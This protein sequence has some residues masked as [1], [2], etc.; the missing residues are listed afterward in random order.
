[1][2]KNRKQ[3]KALKRLMAVCLAGAVAGSGIP[4]YVQAE[5]RILQTL[6]QAAIQEQ[7][8]FNYPFQNTELSFEER[9]A[10]LVSRLT[11]EEK[12]SL[13]TAR[14][15]EGIS[16]VPRLGID[17]WSWGGEANHG[18][19]WVKPKISSF[20]TGSAMSCSWDKELI[21]ETADA[22]SDEARG[23]RALI[24][25]TNNPDLAQLGG[26]SL[27]FW[28]PTMNLNRDP[29]WGR[30]DESYGEDPYLT[31]ELAGS[32][33]RGMQGDDEKYLKTV[34]CLKHF[35]ANNCEKNRYNGSS[36]VDERTL[37]E[38]YAKPFQEIIEATGIAQ[39][40]T[41][42]NSVNGVPM[43]V[44]EPLL[45][46]MLRKTWGFDG[47]VVTDCG[48]IK[49]I[50]NDHKWVP[51]G[52]DRSVNGQEA[53]AFAMKA[54]TDLNCGK[55][56]KQYAQKAL[57]EG[58]LKE[59]DLDRSLLRAFTERM[60]TGEFDPDEMVKYTSLTKEEL[61]SP[62]HIA[63]TEKVANDSV[64]MLKNEAA[65]EGEKPMLPLDGKEMDSVALIGDGRITEK[66]MLGGYSIHTPI[67]STAPI[68]GLCEKMQELNPEATVTLHKPKS[69]TVTTPYLFNIDK[70]LLETKTGEIITLEAEEG[71]TYNCVNEGNNIGYVEPS[72]AFL[73]FPG[74]HIDL[75]DIAKIT[76]VASCDSSAMGGVIQCQ[77]GTPNFQPN[78]ISLA[79]TKV[80]STGSWGNW[81]NF[82]MIVDA[83][84]AELP[85]DGDLYFSFVSE[86]SGNLSKE[87]RK[88]IAEAATAI[89]Y[90]GTIEG[91]DA[92]ED[93]DRKT[94]NLPRRQAELIQEVSSL[95]PNTVV[96]IQSVAQVNVEPFAEQVPAILW[97]G[98]NGQEQGKAF[99]NV[100]FGD[101]NPN[102]KLN[103]TWYQ[104][105]NQIQSITEYGIRSD[106]T[107]NGRTYQYFSG[108]IRYPFGYGLSYTDFTYSNITIDRKE[109]TPNDTITV[110]AD[111]TNSGEVKGKEV[112]QLY[113]KSP[114]AAEKERPV[115][116][117]RGFEKVELEPGE[118]CTVT[119]EVPAEELCYWDEEEGKRIYDPGEYEVEVGA[120]S[121]DIRLKENF[122]MSGEL[123]RKLNVITA[124][125][126]RFIFDLDRGITES[127]IEITASMNDETFCDV[128]KADVTCESSND[129]VAV[130]D[131][132]G[133]IRAVGS[134]TAMITVSI[135][136]EDVTKSVDFP[137]VVRQASVLQ[138]IFV[139][140]KGLTGFMPGTYDYTCKVEGEEAPTITVS[141]PEGIS[142]EIQQAETV[143]GTGIVTVFQGAEQIRYTIEFYHL[144]VSTDFTSGVLNQEEWKVKEE[145]KENWSVDK[146]GLKITTQKGDIIQNQG[147]LKN[148]FLQEVFGDWT[149]DTQLEFSAQPDQRYQQG[150]ILVYQDDD[151]YIKLTC[152]GS[153]GKTIV[154]MAGEQGGKSLTDNPSAA[155]EGTTLYYR[156]KKEGNSYTGWFS[157]DGAEYRELGSKTMDLVNPR[158][159][160]MA[161]NSNQGDAPAIDVIY[162]YTDFS[163]NAEEICTCGLYNLEFLGKTLNLPVD[164]SLTAKAQIRG[165]CVMEGHDASQVDYTYTIPE[166]A[167]NTAEATVENGVLKASRPG[168]VEITVTA[169]LNDAQ[170]VSGKALFEIKNDM[171]GGSLDRLISM[172]EALDAEEYTASSWAE[173]EK[174]LKE[175]KAVREDKNA[176]REETDRAISNLLAAFGNLEYGVQKS[177]LKIAVAAAEELLEKSGDYEDT[178]GLSSAV[179]SGKNVLSDKEADQKTVDEAANRVLDELFKLAKKADLQSLESLIRA[180]GELLDG[181]YTSDSL[182][183]L[184]DVIQK[185]E[186]VIANQDREPNDIGRAYGELVDAI[187]KLERKGSKAALKVMVEKAEYILAEASNYTASTIQ[188]LEEV[189]REAK[190]VYENEDAVQSEVNEAVEKLTQKIA[191]A[192]LLGDVD[193]NGKVTTGDAT[194]VLRAA[195]EFNPVSGDAPASADVNRDGKEDTRDAVLI[196]QYTA[197]EITEF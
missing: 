15:A 89:V 188:G 64:V 186:A 41:A 40:M 81:K 26:G 74:K 131:N 90:V 95:N 119:F 183:N 71:E 70:F 7:K 163:G 103:F 9:A 59:E 37:R 182:Q 38:Y 185:A 92:R 104:K 164:T 133:N 161:T 5:E 124:E 191:Q 115:K 58:L 120:S 11:L 50:V 53:V 30:A 67:H 132:Q 45:D 96:Y 22:I 126:E 153:D 51:E 189:L 105:E 145:D 167:L 181:N 155:F 147:G 174:A 8:T 18:L 166:G 101:V 112:A 84:E 184:K 169:S 31:T 143:P 61:G 29:R 110:T 121:Q 48:A 138:N 168:K 19:S 146:E 10:D 20:P 118:T 79:S 158:L 87:D 141:V 122:C 116:R 60:K 66:V 77:Y 154:K 197:E 88:A 43:S 63:L 137:V 55:Y 23:I 134:G 130:V 44:N 97:A 113:V 177:H 128:D 35:L 54:G 127:K 12:I 142:Y 159:G 99:A 13:L 195:A 125:P 98:Y 93:M 6:E 178:S 109:V 157:K 47:L 83:G 33:V 72:G 165:G 170:P 91:T 73:R 39:I 162:K 123:T 135:Q 117:L 175:A 78:G 136:V 56:Y 86:E 171:T 1:M 94:L 80:S 2:Q 42:Y 24:Q 65:A 150:A 106:E 17:P 34:P 152:E 144:P 75:K 52:W 46:D 3:K 69:G 140:G 190:E 21:Q 149:L 151:N 49:N 32:Y 36:D 82:E 4:G 85:E 114:D 139:D 176:S 129:K 27:S 193:G 107:S 192:R 16:G 62:E 187:M 108:D 179:K 102:G 28:A 173:A 57:D 194:A 25:E 111:I 196:L 76:A 14:R 180:A 156:L 148:L 160:L 68:E 100:L 172:M